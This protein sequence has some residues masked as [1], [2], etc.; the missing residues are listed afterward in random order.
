[1]SVVDDIQEGAEDIA[2]GIGDTVGDAAESLDPRQII[3]E[4]KDWVWGLFRDL[5]SGLMYLPVL[6]VT[7]VGAI[8]LGS[9]LELARS[10]EGVPGLAD[11]PILFAELTIDPLQ[12]I[13]ESIL[14]AVR[15]TNADI[16]AMVTENTGLAAAPLLGLVQ[17][18][19]LLLL[20]GLFYGGTSL[21]R[22]YIRG[23][24]LGG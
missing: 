17:V 23:R 22:G 4:I 11:V 18:A 14:K 9:D 20:A 19:E 15:Q 8:F 5:Y 21:A 13:G 6:L 10:V 2:D 24:Y 16:V 7:V 3:Q 12:P 1:M